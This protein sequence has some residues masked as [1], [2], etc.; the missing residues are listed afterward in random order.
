MANKTRKKAMGVGTFGASSLIDKMKW[1]RTP[2]DRMP[3]ANR[4]VND[5]YGGL[6]GMLLPYDELVRLGRVKP[7]Q[8]YYGLQGN[9]S[10]A[11]RLIEGYQDTLAA[12]DP[13]FGSYRQAV[14][15]GMEGVARGDIPDD[16]RRTLTED[17]RKAQAGR[18]ILDSDVAAIEEAVRL[19]GGREAVRAQRLAE[20]DRYF[21]GVTQG[22]LGAFMPTLGTYL[23][24]D[25][26]S[27]AFN[28]QRANNA[29]AETW[30]RIGLGTD[31]AGSIISGG[32]YANRTS[33]M[34]GT[35]GSGAL[36]ADFNTPVFN[37]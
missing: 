6:E 29:Q 19:S 28:Q 21:S 8:D 32:L 24:A 14:Q 34:T 23:N 1:D 25:A 4:R 13:I 35:S 11:G 9:E 10:R 37:K 36:P 22:A 17:I 33:A 3:S 26:E 18:G 12:A 2:G 16:F 31:I 7:G 20:A 5:A 15:S 27:R 30:R